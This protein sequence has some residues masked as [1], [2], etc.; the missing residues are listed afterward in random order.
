MPVDESEH[1]EPDPRLASALAGV[2]A[3]AF[4]GAGWPW[5][6]PEIFALLN[7]P[8]VAVRLAHRQGAKPGGAIAL[9]GFAL[10]RTAVGEAEVL[11]L[12]VLP[13]A[14]RSGIGAGLLAAC[15]DGARAAGAARLFLEV[16]AGNLAVR[17]LYDR[18]GYRECGQRED[19]YQRPDAPSDD[20]V[21]MEKAL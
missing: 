19:Y 20:A 8:E 12:P 5:S 21:V 18:A 15:E 13:G 7:E 1:P 10:Y 4:A 16:A 3:A 14:R 17:T 6:G 11:T 9:A 2:H